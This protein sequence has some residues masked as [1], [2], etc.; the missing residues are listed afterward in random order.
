M[1]SPCFFLFS[2]SIPSFLYFQLFYR[3]FFHFCVEMKL[4][5]V[6]C[7]VIGRFANENLFVLSFSL[8]LLFVGCHFKCM[9]RYE[10]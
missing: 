2:V 1:F 3:F 7:F 5:C 4:V 9:V 10:D 6:S 8:F